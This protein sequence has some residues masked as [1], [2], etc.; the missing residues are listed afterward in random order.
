MFHTEYYGT[1]QTVT[2]DVHADCV[3]K[4]VGSGNDPSVLQRGENTGTWDE[5][6]THVW[7]V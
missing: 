5:S 2:M 3:V 1:R 4:F 6:T 7:D